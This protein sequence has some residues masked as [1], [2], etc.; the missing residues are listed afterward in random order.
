ML[1]LV[2]FVVE[3]PTSVFKSYY[4]TLV[5]AAQTYRNKSCVNTFPHGGLFFDIDSEFLVS[6]G[7]EVSLNIN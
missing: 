6:R 3:I 5:G 4:I 7:L 1:A 2:N